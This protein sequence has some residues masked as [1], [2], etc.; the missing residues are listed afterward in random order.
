MS[1]VSAAAFNVK[2]VTGKKYPSWEQLQIVKAE[3]PTAYIQ[4]IAEI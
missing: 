2:D 3:N 4:K 1:M